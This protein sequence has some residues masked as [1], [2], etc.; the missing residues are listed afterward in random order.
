MSK[1]RIAS[2]VAAMTMAIPVFAQTDQSTQSST[3]TTT[4][5]TTSPSVV[6]QDNMRANM[7]ASDLLSDPNVHWT[8][9]EQTA[10][11]VAAPYVR[12]SDMWELNHMFRTMSAND[13]RVIYTAL[14]NTIRSNAGDYYTKL[15]AERAYWNSYY[16]NPASVTTTVTTTPSG[17]TAVTTTTEAQGMVGAGSAVYQGMNEYSAWELLQ[18]D[19]NADD[20]TTFRMLWNGMTWS[21]QQAMIDIARQSYYYFAGRRSGVYYNP[22]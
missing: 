12:P 22:Y 5:V 3:T 2:L 13:Q 20:R 9:K 6:T 17:S 11:L 8:I 4:T 19:L 16:N 14:T 21:Q 7:Q 1:I 15:A 10:L 18:H